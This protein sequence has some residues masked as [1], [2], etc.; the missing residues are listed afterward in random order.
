L[1]KDL[2]QEHLNEMQQW[3]DENEER[4]QFLTID[5]EKTKLEHQK[6]ISQMKKEMDT[7]RRDKDQ[8]I[9]DLTIKLEE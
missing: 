8:T 7:I 2:K 6:F 1:V 3:T 9:M 5:L 4:E